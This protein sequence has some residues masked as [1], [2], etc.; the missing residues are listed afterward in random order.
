MVLSLRVFALIFFA[1]AAI[2]SSRLSARAESALVLQAESM[3]IKTSGEICPQGN[4]WALKENGS[5]SQPVVFTKGRYRLEVLARGKNVHEAW[6]VM[7]VKVDGI[8]FGDPIT[9][10]SDDWINYRVEGKLAAGTRDL[11]VE[12]TNGEFDPENK[13]YRQLDIDQVSIDQLPNVGK[14]VPWKLTVVLIGPVDPVEQ[15]E[16]PVKEAVSFIEA[17]TR[18]TFDVQYVVTYANYDYTPYHLGEDIDGDGVGDETAYLMMGW[19]MPA[20]T[21]ESLPVSSSY[22]FLYTM[23]GLRPL[24]AGSALGVK[25]GILKGG[26]PR[27]YSAVP[28]DQFWYSSE[29]YQG[30]SSRAAQILTHEIINTIQG[31]IEAAPYNCSQLTA[32]WGLPA[33]QFESERLLKLGDACYEKLGSNSD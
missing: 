6:P 14:R 2:W 26:K 18:L 4:A 33:A 10:D 28:T 13:E 30:F 21:L 25:Y 9:V 7:Q 5:I 16:T 22:L 24:Q 27:P 17:R 31:K 3:P 20:A 11:S 8:P 23:N 32:K 12:L 1:L 15:A 29:S 19:N